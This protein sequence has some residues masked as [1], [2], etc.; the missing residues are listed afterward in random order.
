MHAPDGKQY[1]AANTVRRRFDNATEPTLARW[2][3]NPEIGF[4]KPIYIGTRRYWL[5][6]EIVAW[7]NECTA[8]DPENTQKFRA[9]AIL[10]RRKLAQRRDH[11]T[12]ITS[13]E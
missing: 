10:A 9:R 8:P 11:D 13:A 7:E 6:D 3:H 2:M 4:P 5:L 12:A 1:L